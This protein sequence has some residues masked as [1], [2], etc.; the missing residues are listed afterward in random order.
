MDYPSQLMSRYTHAWRY[1]LAISGQQVANMLLSYADIDAVYTASKN[2]ILLAL[3]GVNDLYPGRTGAMIYS[4]LRD[5]F[6][7]R[8]AIGFKT[9]AMSVF[10]SSRTTSYETLEPARLELNAL[11]RSDHSFVDRFVDL[12]ADVRLQNYSDTIYFSGDGVHLTDLGYGVM[13]ELAKPA[14]D[15]LLS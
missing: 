4:D 5:Y 1:N 13:A 9:I 11:L 3:G 7:A 15:W 10:A 12:D 8:R 14:A 6:I 2:C